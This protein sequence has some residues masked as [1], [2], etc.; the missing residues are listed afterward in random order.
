MPDM[1]EN[2]EIFLH[3]IE[4]IFGTAALIKC[5]ECTRGGG[6]VSVFIHR[7]A[8]RPGMITGVTYGLSRHPNPDW[9]ESR[10][11]MIISI[12]SGDD[13]WAWMAAYF[14]AEFRGEKRFSSGAVFTTEGPLASDTRMDGV[15]VF[16]QSILDP[17]LEA[18]DVND[19]RIHFSQ[20]YPI[21]SAEL[22]VYRRLGLEVFWKHVNLAKYD[23]KRPPIHGVLAAVSSLCIG[24]ERLAVMHGVRERPRDVLDSGWILASG[25]ESRQFASDAKNY[26]LVPLEMMIDSD[27]TLAP[28]RDCPVGA[29]VT[30]LQ[31]SKPWRFIVQGRVVDEDGNMVERGKDAT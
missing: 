16:E 4:G 26:K 31:V 11:E 17:K 24:Q 15:L 30:R 21:Y 14:C 25:R 10:P 3:H 12:E 9:K 8:P 23:P 6:P 27:A 18:F 19:Y 2:H 20:F 28:L 5:H 29:E 22:D 13:M 1:A 7:D